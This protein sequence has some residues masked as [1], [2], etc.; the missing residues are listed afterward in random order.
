ML[1]KP[2]IH[3]EEIASGLRAHYRLD[4]AHIAFLPIGYDAAAWAYRVTAANGQRSFP[5]CG[6]EP[7]IAP[8]PR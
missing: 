3:D 7:S 2:P 4:V 1:E 5:S 8:R 6:A